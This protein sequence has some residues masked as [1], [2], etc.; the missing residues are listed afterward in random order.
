MYLDRTVSV[1][2][3]CKSAICRP[4]LSRL[5]K[6]RP[7]TRLRHLEDLLIN[8]IPNTI[9]ENALHC[10]FATEISTSRGIAALAIDTRR[11]TVATIPYTARC[12]W[13]HRLR[14]IPTVFLAFHRMTARAFR[15]GQ[16]AKRKRGKSIVS[17]GYEQRLFSHKNTSF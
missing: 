17:C 11:E 4:P 10:V 14:N 5:G 6:A 8:N 12:R 1:V 9:A 2:F 13:H 7:P 3:R 15:H 16:I